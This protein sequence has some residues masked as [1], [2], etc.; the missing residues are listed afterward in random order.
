M[1]PSSDATFA[2]RPNTLFAPRSPRLNLIEIGQPKLVFQGRQRTQQLPLTL[3]GMRLLRKGCINSTLKGGDN[4]RVEF[5]A[6]CEMLTDYFSCAPTKF[7]SGHVAFKVALEQV[8][9][10]P[11]LEVVSAAH[12]TYEKENQGCGEQCPRNDEGYRIHLHGGRFRI[13]A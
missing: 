2:Q 3:F 6:A 1:Q 13:R 9:Q 12:M 4:E 10:Q 8:H 7:L 5:V 11:P